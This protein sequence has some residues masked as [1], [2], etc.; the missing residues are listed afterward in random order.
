[1]WHATCTHINQ[2]DSRLLMVESQIYT[3]TPN[4]SFDHNLCYKYSNGL[5]EPI[6]DIYISRVFQCKEVLNPM[7]FDP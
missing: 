1:M 3:L 7:I 6:L 2:S 5:Y 4:P